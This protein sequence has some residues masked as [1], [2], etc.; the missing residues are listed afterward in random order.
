MI[1]RRARKVRTPNPADY[2]WSGLR[3]FLNVDLVAKTLIELHEV[4]AR[5]HPNVHKQAQ[6]L[7]YCLLQAREYFTAAR[8]VSTATKPNLLYYGTMSLA[9]AEILYKQSGDSSLDKAR[10]QHKH[11]GLT[12][13]SASAKSGADLL[14]AASA[15][16]ARPHEAVGVRQGT[17]ELWHRSSR[18]SPMG[19]EVT[20]HLPEGGTNLGYQAT[21]NAFDNPYPSVPNAGLTLADCFSCIPLMMDHLESTNLKSNLIRGRLISDVWPGTQWRAEHRIILHPS[22]LRD[23]LIGQIKVDPNAVDRI[24]VFEAGLGATIAIYTDWVSGNT[25]MPF[26]PMAVLNS[27]EWRMWTNSPP[28][29]EFGYLYVAIFLA[30]N[31]ARYFPDKWLLDVETSTPLALAIEELCSICEWQAPWLALCELDRTLYVLST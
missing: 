5:F 15:I 14:T 28:L 1:I 29:N 6:Q 16:R 25:N 10:E 18:E 22:D 20:T 24:E 11:H 27:D 17:F 21:F 12:M 19:G 26:P 4:S 9:L 7:R 2:A 30:G 3:K 8:A 31:F 23:E 13:T